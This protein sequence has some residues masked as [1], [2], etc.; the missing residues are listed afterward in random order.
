MAFANPDENLKALNLKPG[1]VVVDFGAG[2]GAYALAAA[3]A[4]QAKEENQVSGKV[5]AVEIQKE[6][7][8]KI[9]KEALSLGVSNLEI[10]WGDVETAGGSGLKEKF[11][12]KVIIS[13]LF[14]QVRAG[15]PLA[16]EAKRILKPNGQI[17]VIDWSDSFGGLGPKP[18]QVVTAEAAEK[19][20]TQA[21]FE[22]EKAFNAGD[23][24][25]GL[26]FKKAA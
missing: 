5:Y 8:A 21:G 14:S 16:L 7:L 24:H 9:K 6:L 1:D 12:D 11:A 20:F 13:N 3:R 25:W 10:I 17:M 15:Y 22:K 18:D 23:H 4:T 19:I 26:I 2:S